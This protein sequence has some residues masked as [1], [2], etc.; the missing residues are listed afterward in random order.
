MMKKETEK[1]S[2]KRMGR[3]E[4]LNLSQIKYDMGGVLEERNTI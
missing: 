1:E 2:E 3:E 4:T